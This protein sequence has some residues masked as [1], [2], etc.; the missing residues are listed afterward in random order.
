MHNIKLKRVKG[1]WPAFEAKLQAMLPGLDV[2]V[3]RIDAEH[4]MIPGHIRVAI[5]AQMQGMNPDQVLYDTG[6][7]FVKWMDDAETV[8]LVQAAPDGTPEEVPPGL[9]DGS[10]TWHLATIGMGT[11]WN[12]LGGLGH[13]DWKDIRIGQID[14]GYTK[15]KAFGY[16]GNT[17][18]IEAEARTFVPGEPVGNGIDPLAGQAFSGH[19]TRTGSVI[20]GYD[21]KATTNPEQPFH[22]V[23]PKAPFV[24][25]RISDS[26][27]IDN[28]QVEFAKA[29]NYLVDEAGVSVVN[30]SMGVL[31]GP[32]QGVVRKALD[33]AYESGVVLLC[34]AGNHV[35]DVMAP[36][37]LSRSLAIAG[38]TRADIPWSGSSYG[39]TADLAAPAYGLWAGTPKGGGTYAQGE[40][41]GTS[42]AV[43]CATGAA[44][45]W[46]L[47]YRDALGGYPG[48]AKVAACRLAMMSSVR[49]P[50]QWGANT[51][52][53]GILNV[54][55]LM[56]TAP[57][58]VAALEKEP[59]A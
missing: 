30:V 40:K 27:A 20:C 50:L 11:A 26:V 5:E 45:L 34:A 9:R 52:G 6:A 32:V 29:L 56:A 58:A 17:W 21:E 24:P 33:N 31:L 38:V 1:T 13:I 55:G 36:A 57:Q 25:V 23:A 49:V 53:K 46:L 42:Y 14:T 16:P 35:R 59:P 28:R 8:A 19:G 18:V 12:Q 10:P 51:H 43:A 54:A 22:G 44:A 48:W 3:W 4:A 41:S 47:K 15:H 39:K 37:K 7:K 2:H